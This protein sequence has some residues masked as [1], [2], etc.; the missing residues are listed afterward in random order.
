MRRF[1][2][3]SLL[4][5]I[6]F[7]CPVLTDERQTIVFALLTDGLR[8]LAGQ[9]LFELLLMQLGVAAVGAL[10][11]RL[12][13]RCAG[14]LAVAAFDTGWPW[15]LLRWLG[16]VLGL[17]VYC[18]LGPALLIAPDTG[19]TVFNDIGLSM[20]LIFVVGIALLP[21]IT[22]YGLLE[23]VGTLARRPFEWLFRLPGRAAVDT[24]ASI[25]SA[26]SIGLLM[27]LSQYERGYYSTREAATIAC[28]FSIVS[29]PFCILIADVAGLETLFFGWYLSVLAACFVCA[30][31]LARIP[32]LARL[33]EDRV[34]GQSPD[35]GSSRGSGL[36]A[37]AEAAVARAAT[38][39][40]FRAY[41]QTALRNYVF[42]A[43]AV[44]GP[45]M[46]L[47]TLAAVLMFHTAV[48]D[49][50][51]WPVSALLDAFGVA[52]STA[53][54]PGFVVGFFDQFM[55]ALV[56]ARLDD[57]F[58]HFVL[59]GLAVAQLVFLSE[60]VL[61]VLRSTLPVGLGVLG[62]VFVLR[63]LIATPV[64]M[65]GGYWVVG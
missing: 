9:W 6:V 4:G 27:T 14:G 23:Y 45:S 12:G 46:V 20:F 22:D 29:I 36:A 41:V 64:L 56:A 65:I 30:A 47:A 18:D 50:L 43:F 62:A 52:S 31:V 51:A 16:F 17:L 53:I 34:I 37:A 48:F 26:S 5:V 61:I 38:A 33:P 15:V 13:V 42:T 63:T 39:P 21:L 54:A 40:G 35:D 1:L 19:V 3:P 10:A 60:F 11:W 58:W 28:N 44:I 55:P 7:F 32:P 57:P 2:L 8:S 49:W 59:G 24:L 25:V